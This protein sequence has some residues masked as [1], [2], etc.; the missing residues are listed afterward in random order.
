MTAGLVRVIL[1]I[2]SLRRLVTMRESIPSLTTVK[3]AKQK[4]Q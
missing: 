3:V 2:A 4:Q 1:L